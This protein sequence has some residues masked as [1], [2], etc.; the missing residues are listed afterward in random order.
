MLFPLTGYWV[1]Y[2]ST[3]LPLKNCI[4]NTKLQPQ[5]IKT[6]QK[7]MLGTKTLAGYASTYSKKPAFNKVY[8]IHFSYLSTVY[9]TLY[10]SYFFS[11]LSFERVPSVLIFFNH[12]RMQILVGHNFFTYY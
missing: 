11:F 9:K 8:R 10:F 6:K 4:A 3:Q 2:I 1:S 5:L 12:Q 7:K